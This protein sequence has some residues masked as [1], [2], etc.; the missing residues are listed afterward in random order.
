M[1]GPDARGFFILVQI[2]LF[3]RTGT[4]YQMTIPQSITPKAAAVAIERLLSTEGDDGLLNPER[5]LECMSRS[6]AE[7][8]QL[9]L[10]SLS[11]DARLADRQLLLG[12]EP[13]DDDLKQRGPD[14]MLH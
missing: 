6:E 9:R 8:W 12:L 4:R 2:G 7:A 5:M 1:D 11:E 14:T 10:A 13:D 3:V